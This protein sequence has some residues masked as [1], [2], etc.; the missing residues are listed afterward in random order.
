MEPFDH[1]MHDDQYAQ[2]VEYVEPSFVC[3][4]QFTDLET[5]KSWRSVHR[6]IR[7]GEDRPLYQPA[8]ELIGDGEVLRSETFADEMF[9]GGQAVMTLYTLRS[10]EP[11][12]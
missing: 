2:T 6:S 4:C 8:R 9:Q 11:H 7:L 12:A 3:V 10:E 1:F 5:G